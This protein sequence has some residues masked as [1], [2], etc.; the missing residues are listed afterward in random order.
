[1]TSVRRAEIQHDQTLETLGRKLDQSIDSF[2]TLDSSLNGSS[3]TNGNDRNGRPD[4]GG[5]VA[6]QIGE[7]LED[8]DKQRR[9]ALDATFLIQCWIEVSENGQLT[10]LEDMIRR[11][12]SGE[13]ECFQ[14]M[15]L[16]TE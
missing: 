6:V 9:R 12:G 13:N 16:S 14:R 5:N 2:E 1:M 11:Q 8:L 4:G 10:S 3:G 15:K 7:R